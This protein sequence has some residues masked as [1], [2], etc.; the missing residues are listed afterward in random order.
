[1]GYVLRLAIH[2]HPAEFDT[3]PQEGLPMAAGLLHRPSDQPMKPKL[4]GAHAMH[5]DLERA[6][7]LH[8]SKS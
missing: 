3:M 7:A 2:H 5:T 4:I 1:M 8:P 6:L